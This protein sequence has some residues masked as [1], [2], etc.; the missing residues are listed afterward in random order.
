MPEDVPAVALTPGPAFRLQEDGSWETEEVPGP[1]IDS[2]RFSGYLTIEGYRCTVFETPEGDQYAQRSVV[3][4]VAAEW[5]RRQAKG[6]PKDLVSQVGDILDGKG[7]QSGGTDAEYDEAIVEYCEEVRKVLPK[8]QSIF[9]KAFHDLVDF[10]ADGAPEAKHPR[11]RQ[12]GQEQVSKALNEAATRV[13]LLSYSLAEELE[14][15][16]SGLEAGASRTASV[17]VA[18]HYNK[19]G[20]GLSGYS[21]EVTA[22]SPETMRT[23]Y[24]SGVVYGAHVAGQVHV[25]FY[26]GEPKKFAFDPDEGSTDATLDEDVWQ[27]VKDCCLS[28]L[29]P[30]NHF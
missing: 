20:P 14:G 19:S 15:L 17:R 18:K 11:V 16:L 22:D 24:V 10:K 30:R 23:V 5:L 27:T 9:D 6:G 12:I 28:E 1:V 4:A 13:E 7:G 8:M 3:A 29:D 2:A 21:L 25:T 26:D